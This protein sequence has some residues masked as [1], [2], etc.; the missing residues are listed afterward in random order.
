[1]P[2]TTAEMTWLHRA[3]A[4]RSAGAMRVAAIIVIRAV[5]GQHPDQAELRMASVL[6]PDEDR[7]HEAGR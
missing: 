2:N 3:G 5:A 4:T 1:M 7:D 6:R